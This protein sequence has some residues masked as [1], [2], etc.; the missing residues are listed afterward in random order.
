MNPYKIM[1]FALLSFTVIAHIFAFISAHS[2]D[3]ELTSNDYY[4][5]EIRYQDTLEARRRA[6][7]FNWQLEVTGNQATLTLSHKDQTPFPS[8]IH[9]YFYRPQQASADHQIVFE[10]LGD[11][12]YRASTGHVS[13]GL[14]KVTLTGTTDDCIYEHQTILQQ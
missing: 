11:G 6:Q 12:T 14:W 2:I 4:D 10:P 13:A 8:D 7:A 1:V 3:I 5:R 9:A